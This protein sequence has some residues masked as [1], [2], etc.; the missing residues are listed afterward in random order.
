MLL[1]NIPFWQLVMWGL[2]IALVVLIYCYKIFSFDEKKR[3]K[4]PTHKYIFKHPTGRINKEIVIDPTE[5]GIYEA[6]FLAKNYAVK[7]PYYKVA[8]VLVNQKDFSEVVWMG[9]DELHAHI[10]FNQYA[11]NKKN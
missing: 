7:H 9:Y 2:G 3:M 6:A 4:K 11:K 5:R 8:E 1:L 10:R